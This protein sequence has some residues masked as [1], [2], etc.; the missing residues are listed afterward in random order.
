MTT[1]S[2]SSRSHGAGL[3]LFLQ[4]E[5]NDPEEL[6]RL[7]RQLRYEIEELNVGSVELLKEGNAPEGTKSIEAV[8]LGGLAL[9]ILPIIIPKFIEFLQQWSLRGEGRK[10]RIRTQ[11]G[12]RSLEVEYSPSA[13]SQAELKKLVHTLTGS[14]TEKAPQ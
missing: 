4:V 13:M 5:H 11:I 9:T 10:V 8:T 7:A 1:L 12:D 6:D 14:L 3:T 2:T